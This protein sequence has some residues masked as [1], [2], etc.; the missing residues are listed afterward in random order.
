MTTLADAIF[1]SVLLPRYDRKT[2]RRI[3]PFA[4][5]ASVEE[6]IRAARERA[7]ARK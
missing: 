3:H 2:G 1:A 7:R 4:D 5:Y 6:D